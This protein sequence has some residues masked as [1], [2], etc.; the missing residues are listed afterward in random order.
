MQKLALTVSNISKTFSEEDGTTTDALYDISCSITLGEFF[1]ILGPSGSGKSTLLRIMCG[2]E[3]SSHGK[4]TWENLK[5][6][7][8]A[9][10]FQQFGLLP[11]LA[12]FENIR[13]GLLNTSLSKTSQE[14]RVMKRI[15]SL[16]LEAFTHLYPRELS[17]GMKQRVGFARALV[18]NP[19]I[20]FLDEPFSELD[21]FT[22]E[23]LRKELLELWTKE[24]FTVI[25]VTHN[26]DEAIELAD[27]VA[28]LTPRP[29]TI[30]DIVSIREKHPRIMRSKKAFALHDKI[31]A[32]VRP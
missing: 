2:L 17:G 26:V 6:T 22:A 20:L 29:G 15:K 21:T 32:L 25:M 31:T 9:F 12:V 8:A 30:E 10:V 28:V 1:V 27:R 18:V 14:K 23:T 5:P 16:G 19:K 4:I 7:D 24:Q 11:W 3:S 13:L